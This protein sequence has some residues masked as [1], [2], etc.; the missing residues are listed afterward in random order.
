VAAGDKAVRE[1]DGRGC[2]VVRGSERGLPVRQP[3]RST[4]R[5]EDH[6]RP[7]DSEGAH[8]PGNAAR[9][10]APACQ[11]RRGIR[12]RHRV[13]RKQSR[14]PEELSTLAGHAHNARCRG[15]KQFGVLP[16]CQPRPH[17]DDGLRRT[18]ERCGLCGPLQLSL[19]TFKAETSETAIIE[20][21]NDLV[22]MVGGRGGGVDRGWRGRWVRRPRRP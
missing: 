8:S 20:T 21:D 4:R 1:S 9:G 2:R 16:R 11:C 3:R 14:R 5:P 6:R 7:V 15:H 13:R 18:E 22:V 10:T 17:G 19:S 12:I